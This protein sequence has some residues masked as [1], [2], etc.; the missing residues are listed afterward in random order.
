[1]A[2]AFLPGNAGRKRRPQMQ[3]GERGVGRE[4]E[5]FDLTPG[6]VLTVDPLRAQDG[7]L[8]ALQRWPQDLRAHVER[9]A[10]FRRQIQALE[11]GC[12]QSHV[13][14]S[15]CGRFLG[16]IGLDAY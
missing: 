11:I 15:A 2:R 1:M 5:G 6:R 12:C 16:A 14:S 10:R 7:R 3:I 9:Y 4:L 13:S 8:Q